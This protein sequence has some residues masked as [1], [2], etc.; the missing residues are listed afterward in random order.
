ME[1][2]QKRHIA[3]LQLRIAM[4]HTL[5]LQC[6]CCVYVSCHPATGVAHTRIIERRAPRCPVR[7]HEVGARVWLW[8][9]LPDRQLEPHERNPVSEKTQQ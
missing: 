2:A 6:G 9:L 7:R 4:S 5:T 3:M 8:E 1:L